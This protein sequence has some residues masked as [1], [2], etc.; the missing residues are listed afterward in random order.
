MVST[1]ID[2]TGDIGDAVAVQ[3]D[4]KVVVVGKTGYDSGSS[5]LAVVRYNS[6]R[7]LD[8]SFGS[9]GAFIDP[10]GPNVVEQDPTHQSVVIQ[11]DG[12]IVVVGGAVVQ[13]ITKVG[14][15]TI[16]TDYFDWLVFRLTSNGALDTTFGSGGQ[17]ITPFGTRTRS[18]PQSVAIQPADG[19]IVV[20]GGANPSTTGGYAESAVA[21]YNL[22]GSL[23][24]TFGSGG[25]VLTDVSNL[26]GATGYSSG[27]L[28]LAIDSSGR[29]IAAGSADAVS[30]IVRGEMAMIRLTPGGALDTAFGTGGAVAAL[31][32]TATGGW[33]VGVGFQSGGQI[34]MGGLSSGFTGSPD[35]YELAIARFTPGGAL[36]T[37]FGGG[38]GFFSTTEIAYP[39]S[40]VVDGNGEILAVGYAYSSPNVYD[41]NFWVSRV[42][43]D[44]SGADSAF[45]TNGVAEAA[46]GV[47]TVPTSV[48]L[49]PSGNIVLAGYDVG[50]LSEFRTARFLG[51][52]TSAPSAALVVQDQAAARAGT[53]QNAVPAPT[54]TGLAPDP[55]MAALVLDS[56]DFFE[57][58]PRI[59]R[60]P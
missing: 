46:F 25:I 55:G 22:D 48:A 38:S 36:D 31:A 26:L 8:T 15:K 21:R 5:H 9:G 40:L 6:D 30:S 33:A 52:S 51:G 1:N 53:T 43:A 42:L 37:T 24:T 56:P 29:I 19:K 7:S 10:F 60:R 47:N 12:K 39:E 50:T 59:R 16:T 14:K 4:S 32:P 49:D 54:V 2:S 35:K 23:D 13:V 44:G 27:A 45:G 20:A 28:S 57:T 17:V 18:L 11:G 58:L 3:P 34:I 41:Q